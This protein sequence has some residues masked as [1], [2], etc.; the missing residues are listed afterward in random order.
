M[1]HC[2]ASLIF[3]LT[4]P[5]GGNRNPEHIPLADTQCDR[6]IDQDNWNN[7]PGG[8]VAGEGMGEQ[9]WFGRS[10]TLPGASPL[11]GAPPALSL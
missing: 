11:A 2:F 1:P 4:M 10:L 7:D 9:P 6:L 5:V 3:C 8:D